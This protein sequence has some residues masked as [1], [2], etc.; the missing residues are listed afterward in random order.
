MRTAA[1]AG[2]PPVVGGSTPTQLRKERFPYA[3]AIAAGVI[4]TMWARGMLG[5]FVP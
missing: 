2:G 1:T 4:V 3:V 5:V